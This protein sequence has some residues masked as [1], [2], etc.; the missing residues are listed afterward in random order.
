MVLPCL[1]ELKRDIFDFNLSKE[2]IRNEKCR[3]E[4]DQ[5]HLK[6]DISPKQRQTID[7]SPKIEVGRNNANEE[8]V[9]KSQTEKVA[10][11]VKRVKSFFLESSDGGSKKSK[12]M[13]KKPWMGRE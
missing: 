1:L 9:K 4:S 13:K 6:I 7:T 8:T 10:D 3:I 12:L 5:S 11:K 2:T